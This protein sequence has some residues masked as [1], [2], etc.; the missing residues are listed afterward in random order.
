MEA[1]PA[2]ERLF[3]DSGNKFK[4]SDRT[5]LLRSAVIYGGNASG[6]SNFIKALATMKGF[7]LSSHLFLEGQDFPYY[8][9]FILNTVNLHYP[10]LMECTYLHEGII[11]RYGFEF[12]QARIEKEWLYIKK[13]RETKVFE[14]SGGE[15][16]ITPKCTILLDL[17]QKNMIRKNVLMLSAGAQFNETIAASA[18]SWFNKLRV[19]SGLLDILYRDFTRSMLTDPAKKS[20][21]I[22]LLKF[23]DSGIRGL[24]VKKTETPVTEFTFHTHKVEE[25]HVVQKKAPIPELESYRYQKLPTGAAKM[26]AVPFTLFESEGTQKLFH[27][28]GPVLDSLENGLILVIDEFDVKLHPHLQERLV[29]MFH[30]NN[31]N[32]NNAQ[33]IFTTHNTHLL[34]R[35]IF[36][37]DQVW[38]TERDIHEGT[39]IYSPIE[40]KDGKSP[41]NDERFEKNYNDGKYGGVPFLGEFDNYLEGE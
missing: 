26:I 27:L 22:K 31:L 23:A 40:F 2:R 24:K 21:V 11:Y 6:K 13:K 25:P 32:K 15:F 41:R 20:A 12:K 29:L 8:Q 30:N 1:T 19:I 39:K 33:L 3:D 7:V 14:R 17:Y 4:I 10:V 38:L 28:A 9:P 16:D 36:R 34:G 35:K 18:L 37:R 5:E